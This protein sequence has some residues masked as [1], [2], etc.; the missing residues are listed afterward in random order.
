[1]NLYLA[2]VFVIGVAG[3]VLGIL[4]GSVLAVVFA[5]SFAIV[6]QLSTDLSLGE[7]TIIAAVSFAGGMLICVLGALGPIQ[8]LKKM[9]PLMVIKAE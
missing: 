4:F 2:E 6:K 7:R 9:E 5:K 1:M 8:R 3:S